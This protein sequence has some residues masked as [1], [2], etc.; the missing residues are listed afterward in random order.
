MGEARAVVS[1]QAAG[2]RPVGSLVTLTAALQPGQGGDQQG[3]DGQHGNGHHHG[4]SA[5]N[6]GL[7]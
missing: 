6:S 7:D 2:P 1:G 5:G 3:G 4:R